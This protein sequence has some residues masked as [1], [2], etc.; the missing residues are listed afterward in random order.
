MPPTHLSVSAK[1]PSGRQLSFAEREEIAWL[2]RPGGAARARS[3]ASAAPRRP[4]RA[5][6]AATRQAASS[7][8]PRPRGGTA[9]RA[10][11]RP[12][13]SPRSWLTDEALRRPVEERLAG[14]I[15]AS[16]G[17]AVPGPTVP[18]R[19]RRSIRRQSRRW[20]RAWS[21]ERIARRLPID[22]SE[23]QTM[24]IS[25]EASR[26]V[27]LHPGPRR[28]SRREL[29]ACLRD[30]GGRG[31]GAAGAHA[32]SAQLLRRLRIDGPREAAR[33]R[34]ASPRGGDRSGLA[35]PL[36]GALLSDNHP[37]RC[38]QPSWPAASAS[39]RA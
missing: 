23:D 8:A 12:K 5:S 18:W 9:R 1:P 2:A 19:A 34:S 11:R 38:R 15:A 36:G 26:P 35:G 10:A 20:A 13:R 24:R 39:G 28:G 31:P 27:A 16:K 17:A 21:P 37:D 7:A 29:S 4:S 22:V 3:V 6:G 25:H 33:S 30:V 32:R 14:L